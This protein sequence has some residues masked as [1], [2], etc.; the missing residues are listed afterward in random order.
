MASVQQQTEQRPG[1]IKATRPVDDTVTDIAMK[2]KP[3]IE[4]K[5]TRSLSTYEPKQVATQ[6]SGPNYRL[7]GPVIL[8]VFY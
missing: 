2:I 6:V 4:A 5:L 1:G 7:Y 3:Q 8:P